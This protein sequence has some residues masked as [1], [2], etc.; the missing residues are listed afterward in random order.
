M[1]HYKHKSGAQKR[2]EREK[3]LEVS[4]KGCRTLFDVGIKVNV[5]NDVTNKPSSSCD[6]FSSPREIVNILPQLET[7][8]NADTEKLCS[9]E[10]ELIGTEARIECG[11][12][13]DL[14]GSDS[15]STSPLHVSSDLGKLQSL[16]LNANLVETI[17][18]RGPP[19]LPEN[20]PSD[21]KRAFPRTVL[22]TK[23]KNGEKVLRDWLVWS[24][25]NESLFC[26]PCR[27]FS[28]SFGTDTPQSRKSVL[29]SEEGWKKEYSWR[30]LYDKLP[31]HEVSS[32]HRQCY[33]KWRELENRLNQGT[34]I[35]SQLGS[36]IAEKVTFWRDLFR[37]ILSVVLFLS[38]RGLGFRGTSNKIG[39]AN[40][41]NFLGIIELLAEYD[42]LLREH[43]AKVKKSQQQGKRLQAHY[44][45]PDSQNQFIEA[46]SARVLQAILS[47]REQSKYFAL[48][49]DATPDTS[50]TEQTTFILRFVLDCESSFKIV[51]RFLSF[52]ACNKKTGRDIANLIIGEMEKHKIPL[53]DCR[54]QGY[55]NGANMAGIYNGAQAIIRELNQF[56]IFSNCGAHSLNLC[57][58]NAAECCED[59]VTF[60]GMVQKVYNFFSRSP[61]RWEILEKEIGCSLHSLSNTRWSARV[62]S[63]KPF[64][65]HLPLIKRALNKCKDLNLSAECKTELMGIMQYLK[66]FNCYLMATVWLKI[67]VAI[68]IRSKVLQARNTTLDVEVANIQCLIEELKQLRDQWKNILTETKLVAEA[69]A[70]D[71]PSDTDFKERRIKKRKTFH[72]EIRDDRSVPVLD[73]DKT[74]EER[75]FRVNVF[76]KLVDSVVS[77]LTERFTV[78]R[79]VS[80]IFKFLWQYLDTSDDDIKS[81]CDTLCEKYFEDI[82]IEIA[83]EVKLLKS[84][85]F[86]NIGPSQLKPLQLLNTLRALKL[87]SLFPNVCIAIRL[88]CT[89]PVTSAEAERSF[90]KMKDIKNVHRSTMSQERMSGLSLLALEHDVARS[91]NYD[92]IINDFAL[93]KA[94]KIDL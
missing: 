68:D 71:L 6:S 57:G 19:K 83:D 33:I 37:R 39:E 14:S 66:S 43:V 11:S 29:C 38:E 4:K 89:I 58:L 72:D 32:H 54:G 80:E 55:D 21:G 7:L 3:K 31:S 50:H 10:D 90:S 62:D 74:L 84:I 30:K 27:L 41:G 2:K 64:A 17:V 94:R 52:V 61:S 78:A 18:R 70:A 23:H 45:S 73:E 79:V 1:E 49:V 92:D 24:E 13:T 35:Y 77:G 42:P 76:Y 9:G 20:L 93:S 40:N 60:F 86:S 85:H 25:T 15:F 44:L 69:M 36:D 82:N 22:S 91:L 47:E 75:H 81:M 46:C 5:E 65:T 48:L 28:C 12:K 8:N 26:F 88:F 34:G 63:V 53:A 51:E 59:V 67:L 16:Y 56:A 87:D